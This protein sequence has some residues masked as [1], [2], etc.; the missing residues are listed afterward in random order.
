M[1]APLNLRDLE[2][3]A[4]GLLEPGAQA[5]FAG[6]AHDEVCLAENEAAWARRKLLPRVLVDV[7]ALDTA[8]TLLGTAVT[9]PVGIAPTAQHGLAH[10]DAEAATARAAAAAGVLY[11]ASTMSTLPVERI[12]AA[13]SGP[14]WFQLY[15]QRDRA[16]TLEL[17]AR[18]RAAGFTA[19]VLTVDTPVAGVRERDARVGAA[20]ARQTFGN[21]GYSGSGDALGAYVA[22]LFDP[23]VTWDDLSWLRAAAGMPLVLKGIMTAA[24]ARLACEH[25]ADA[26]WVSNHGGRQL[27][28]T[29][30][31]AD[32]L[33][34]VAGAAAGRAEVYVDGGIR[35]GLDVVTALALGAR[36]VFVGRPVLYALAC[37][38]QAGVTLAL[39]ML[40][41][42]LRNAMALLGAPSVADVRR[43]HVI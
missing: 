41:A 10:P 40:R 8:T 28:R 15:I 33:E 24:D 1:S 13:G 29:P 5:Y 6:G 30:A 18:A 43:S 12:G 17:V 14:R 27:D 26:V 31:T 23:S 11:C 25:G 37:D 42:E 34:E 19:L 16:A 7:G 39:E 22:G 2:R 21:L 38:G 35:R 9:M 36:A 4:G 32:V 20:A 3:I